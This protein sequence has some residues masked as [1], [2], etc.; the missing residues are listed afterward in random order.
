M[1]LCL[2]FKSTCYYLVYTGILSTQAPPAYSASDGKNVGRCSKTTQTYAQSTMVR[3]AKSRN[4]TKRLNHSR[5]YQD[6]AA[7]N[8]Q[9]Q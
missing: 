2:L 6:P 5:C 9:S 3:S 8:Q 4:A 7:M 1:N